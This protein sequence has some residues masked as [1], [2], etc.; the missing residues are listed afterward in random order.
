MN[1]INQLIVALRQVYPSKSNGS[2]LEH[3]EIIQNQ[4]IQF[5]SNSSNFSKLNNHKTNNAFYDS[6]N[7]D[8]DI[9]EIELF[10]KRARMVLHN[11]HSKEVTENTLIIIYS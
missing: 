7:I 4:N 8:E 5:P 10:S 1:I 2:L 9:S 3:F 11:Y 6:N